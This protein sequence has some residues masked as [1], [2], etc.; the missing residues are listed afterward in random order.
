M[1]AELGENRDGNVRVR[2]TFE[3]AEERQAFAKGPTLRPIV[4]ET[5]EDF[6]EGE[7]HLYS[8]TFGLVN[9]ASEEE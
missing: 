3:T 2:I 7:E 9:P 1:K 5:H 4:C 8:Y 6:F